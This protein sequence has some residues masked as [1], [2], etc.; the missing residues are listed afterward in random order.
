MDASE[1]W[2]SQQA[3]AFF[4]KLPNDRIVFTVGRDLVLNPAQH[5]GP[6]NYFI[7][8]YAEV[9]GQPVEGIGKSFRFRRVDGPFA[10]REKNPVG[11]R[12]RGE[13]S[14]GR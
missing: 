10:T 6:L 7:Y 5:G 9:A 1:A 11:R 14:G 2:K 12:R 4:G 13:N 3:D 8:P